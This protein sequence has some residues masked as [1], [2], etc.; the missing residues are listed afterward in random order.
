MLAHPCLPL[1][2]AGEVGA[3]VI[4]QIALDIGLTRLIQESE[5]IGPEIRIKMLD[6]G[7]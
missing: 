5:F 6:V 1:R 7:A 3:I 4:E 2:I